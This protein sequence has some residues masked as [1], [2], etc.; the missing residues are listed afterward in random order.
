MNASVLDKL[1]TIR[2]LCWEIQASIDLHEAVGLAN[3]IELLANEIIEKGK[4]SP[5]ISVGD[6]LYV[7]DDANR[8]FLVPI[9]VKNIWTGEDGKM[10]F[11]E[12][13]GVP[14]FF[15]NDLISKTEAIKLVKKFYQDKL[16]NLEAMEKEARKELL[17]KEKEEKKDEKDTRNGK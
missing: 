7:R 11:S 9:T 2:G 13:L 6:V 14:G 15:Q 12:S 1:E 10:R 16:A 4:K 3:D 17:G 5:E 8:G